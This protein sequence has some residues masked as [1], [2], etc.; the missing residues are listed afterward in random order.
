MSEET[1]VSLSNLETAL[2]EA[3]NKSVAAAET[4]TDFVIGELPGFITEVLLWYGVHSFILFVAGML[5]MFGSVYCLRIAKSKIPPVP[6]NGKQTWFWYYW[7]HKESHEMSVAATFSV[8]GVCVS[9]FVIFMWGVKLLNL[10]WLKIW[11]APKLFL[12]EYAAQ[13]VK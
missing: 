1:Q 6:E 4:A 12:I 8:M 11:I 5:M 2:A 13:M 3:I 9:A 7:M 10:T